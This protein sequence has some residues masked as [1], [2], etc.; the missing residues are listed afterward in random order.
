MPGEYQTR[1]E[2]NGIN[3][4]HSLRDAIEEAKKDLT[5]WKISW[6]QPNAERIRLVRFDNKL[7]IYEPIMEESVP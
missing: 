2:M 7:W 4:H 1:S 5:I 6:S 3:F